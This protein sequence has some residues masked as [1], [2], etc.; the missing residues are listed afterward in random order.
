MFTLVWDSLIEVTTGLKDE[1][2]ETGSGHV[3]IQDE[4]LD[5]WDCLVSAMNAQFIVT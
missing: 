2:L 5:S 4:E 1:V 3:D